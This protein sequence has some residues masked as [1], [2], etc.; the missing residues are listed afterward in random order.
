[1]SDLAALLLPALGVA[2]VGYTDNVLDGPGVRRPQPATRSTPTRSCWPWATANLAAGVVQGFPVSSSGSRTV[3]RA[4]PWAA[5]ASCTR[6]WR[7][8]SCWPPCCSCGRC[9]PCSPTAALGALVVY[10]AIRLVDVAEF[11]RIA[12]VP[13]Q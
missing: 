9:S 2:V 7:W 13:P 8:P 3:D 11:R 12:P 6:W 1:M 5:G 4:T 10:A